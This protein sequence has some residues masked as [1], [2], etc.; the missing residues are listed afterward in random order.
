MIIRRRHTANFTTIGNALF[1]DE[2]L[3]ADELGIL[4]F[5]RSKPP[6]W[7]VR[8]PA[9]MKRFRI[10]RDA[11]RRIV[12]NWMRAGWC[13]AKKERRPDG[14]FIIV[15]EIRD[16]RGPELSDEEIRRALSPESGEAADEDRAERAPEIC[17]EASQSGKLCSQPDTSQ[18][19]L[20]HPSTAR[21]YVVDSNILNTE[22]PRT[23][24]N[25]IE[26]EASRAKGKHAVSLV[27]FKQRYPT[28]ASDDQNR[29]DA[30]WF[31][32]SLEEGDA[33]IAGIPAFLEKLKRDGRKHIPASF[34]YLDQKRWTLLE[35]DKTVGAKPVVSIFAADTD[36]ARAITAIHAVARVTPF[37]LQTGEI[38]YLREVTEQLKAMAKAPPRS[39]WPFIEDRNQIGAWRAFVSEC[40]KRSIPTFVEERNGSHGIFAPWPWPPRKD[41]TLSV[42]APDLGCSED[43][44]QELAKAR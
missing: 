33:A 17:A 16:D 10:G 25:Q 41:G 26:R 14:T 23:E 11:M 12:S 28:A 37:R 34:T 6:D 8:R 13:D 44:L 7:E 32:L 19:V 22:L 31:R 38:S 24:S 29:L 27:T 35:T 43:D 39:A 42:I 3:A 4:A 5:L 40:V 18:P 21:P 20:A 9:L 1:D 30:A 15:Y 2:R 36:E